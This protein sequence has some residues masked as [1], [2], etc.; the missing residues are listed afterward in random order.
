MTI[1]VDLKQEGR[2]RYGMSSAAMM[3]I[4]GLSAERWG[5]ATNNRVVPNSRVLNGPAF[6]ATLA[7]AQARMV[8]LIELGARDCRWGIGDGKPQLFCGLPQE[9]A[10]ENCRVRRHYCSHHAAMAVAKRGEE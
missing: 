3:A 2:A 9:P 7:P 6:D 10:H 5:R 4:K 8:P 1:H